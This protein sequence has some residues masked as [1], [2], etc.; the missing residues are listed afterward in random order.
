MPDMLQVALR[1]S[2]RQPEAVRTVGDPEYEV[3][4]HRP[5]TFDG[6]RVAPELGTALAI[7]ARASDAARW[8]YRALLQRASEIRE[9]DLIGCEENTR[10]GVSVR[11]RTVGDE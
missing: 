9:R 1:R 4:P 2:Q 11:D 8:E 5:S 10:L 6:V 3:P 7:A